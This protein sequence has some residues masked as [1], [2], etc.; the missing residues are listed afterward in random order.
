MLMAETSASLE[1]HLCIHACPCLA[2]LRRT[3]HLPNHPAREQYRSYLNTHL[4]LTSTVSWLELGRILFVSLSAP[5]DPLPGLFAFSRLCSSARTNLLA[6]L[7]L[8]SFSRRRALDSNSCQSPSRSLS[9]RQRQEES[10][11]DIVAAAVKVSN[12]KLVD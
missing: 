5:A 7:S 11:R 9:L 10:A 8:R 6:S 4:H 2:H 1:Q 3:N 12:L